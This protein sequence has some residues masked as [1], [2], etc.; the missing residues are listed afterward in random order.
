M[1]VV[2]ELLGYKQIKIIQNDEMF[3][4]SVD[5][6]LLADFV[7]IPIKT[8]KIIDLGCG[9]APIPLFLTLKTKAK[10]IGVELQEVIADMAKR[11][12]ELNHFESQIEIIH[13]DLKNI[14]QTV[15][16]NQFDIVISNPPY[17]KYQE[18][19]HINKNSFLT[20]AR[21]EVKATLEDIIQEARKLLIDGGLFYMVH[22]AERLTEILLSLKE[23]GFAMKRIRF[24][25]PKTN[26]SEALLILLEAK[27]NAKEGMKIGQPLYIY[28]DMGEYTEEVRN[29][30]H[31]SKM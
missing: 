1:E 6:M 19:S 7:R 15:G 23:N 26:A 28:D 20:I 25:Y 11:S 17:F 21:H 27:K 29:I 16:A 18:S 31:F 12:V 4:F 9:N 5:S 10:I 2:H 14:Y 8:K 24:V 30:F 13:Q 3:C 22:R